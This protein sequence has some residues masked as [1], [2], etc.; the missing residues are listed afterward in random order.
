MLKANW[1]KYEEEIK[2]NRKKLNPRNSATASKE[3]SNLMVLQMSP[4][5][6]G[7]TQKYHPLSPREFVPFAF[8]E[9]T[10]ENIK[11]ACE[12]HFHKPRGSCDVLASD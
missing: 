3:I 12:D 1:D 11:K 8:S 5:A 7:K 9:L 2:A 4:E 6:T 10:I